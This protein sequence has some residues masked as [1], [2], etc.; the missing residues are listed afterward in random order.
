[1]TPDFLEEGAIG[2]V[3]D[4]ELI[5]RLWPYL[6]P[7]WKWLVASFALVPVSFVLEATPAV[8]VG[9][10]LNFAAGSDAVPA[11]RFAFLAALARAPAGV[12]LLAWLAGVFLSVALLGA[13]VQ[14]LRTI[15]MTLM[16]ERAM[17]SLRADLFDHVQRLGLRF[18]DTYPV[19]RLVTRLTHDPESL[20]EMFSSGIVMLIADVLRMLAFAVALFLI[21][22]RLA[23]VSMAVMPLLALAAV[24]F[25]Y[26]VREAYREVRVWIARINANL[27]ETLTGMRVVQLFARERR[28]LEDFRAINARHRDAWYLSIHYDAL[29]SATLEAAGLVVVALILWYGGRLIQADA[30]ELGTLLLFYDWTRRF[31]MP[32]QDL[33]AKYSVMQSSMA[34]LERVFELLD[35]PREIEIGESGAPRRARRGG[36]RGRHVRVRRGSGAARRL[37][38]RRPRRTRGVRR[39]HRRGQDDDP[40]AAGALLRAAARPDPDRR[41]RRARARARRA[42]QAHGLRAAGRVPVHRRPGRTTSAWARPTRTTVREA[43]RTVHLDALLARLP[44]GLAQPVR[45][46]GANFSLGERQLLSFAR[47]LA[48]RPQILLLDEATASVDTETEALVQDGLETPAA[49]QDLAGG[50]PSALDHPGRRPDLRA[51]PRR[52]PRGRHPRRAAGAPRPVL[53]AVPA[54]VRRLVTHSRTRSALQY[55]FRH[56]NLGCMRLRIWILVTVSLLIGAL[57]NAQ[58]VLVSGGASELAPGGFARGGPPSLADPAVYYFTPP[59]C[60]LAGVPNETSPARISRVASYVVIPRPV[61][62]FNPTRAPGVCNPFALQSNIAADATQLYWFDNQDTFGSRLVRL[63]RNANPGDAVTR[64]ASFLAPPLGSQPNEIVPAGSK[65]FLI[66]HRAGEDILASSD[67]NATGVAVTGLVT[68]RPPN[69]MHALQYDGRWV[70]WLEGSTL[71]RYDTQTLAVQSIDVNVHSFYSEGDQSLC[72]PIGCQSQNSVY[73]AKGD[74]VLLIDS[75]FPASPPFVIYTAPASRPGAFVKEFTRDNDD[76]FFLEVHAPFLDISNRV[77]RYPFAGQ[78]E[79]I[80]GPVSQGLFGLRGL[81]NDNQNLIWHEPGPGRIVSIKNNTP[82]AFLLQAT[83]LEVTQGI[84]NLSNDVRLIENKRTL[85][86]FYVR[87]GDARTVRGVTATLSGFTQTT[88]SLGTLQPINPDGKLVDVTSAPTRAQLTRS[89][90]FELPLHWTTNGPLNLVASVNPLA[91][92]FENNP[93]DNVAAVGPLAFTPTP[94]AHV[95]YLNVGYLLDGTLYLPADEDVAASQRSGPTAL[96]DRCSARGFPRSGPAHYADHPAGPRSGRPRQADAPRLREALSRGQ[97]GSDQGQDRRPQPVRFRRGAR[98]H[99]GAAPR[100]GHPRGDENLREHR[101]GAEPAGQE[102][103]HARLWRGFRGLRSERSR[104]RH[105]L[106]ELR[107]TRDRSHARA[108]PPGNGHGLWPQCVRPELSVPG[109]PDR[110]GGHGRE[111]VRLPR[112]PWR[113]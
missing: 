102:L 18:F 25:R 13:A 17:R 90:Q 63:S 100:G 112:L 71:R 15:V 35:V 111:R 52:D 75:F 88:G 43:A 95:D 38:P 2:K 55:G 83:G 22:W 113:P 27:Q 40:Q 99:R 64:M 108:R 11:G 91:K 73:V 81:M 65:L 12:P 87:S 1:M 41:R 62:V 44:A 45:E 79:L 32:L 110:A 67:T 5:A 70:W 16:G 47:A 50:R 96:P 61:F 49:R 21:D 53:E 98:P 103:F 54:P 86:R 107:R 14:F 19:G 28:N 105:L 30:L 7:H 59:T 97:E 92:V 34:S 76:L 82:G 56:G 39:P 29:L 48:R 89:F 78:A 104:E 84:Q 69:S 46:R 74:Q 9:R 20:V 94:R 51:A 106:P 31:L 26:K 6:R 93:D 109:R 42:A 68:G 58:T 72:S 36:L 60:N 24:V 77:F 37:V 101:A 4:R 66:I 57:A 3:Y 33:S 8:L 80:Y 23:A 85:V 10:A